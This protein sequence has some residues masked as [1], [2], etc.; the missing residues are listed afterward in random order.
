MSDKI[1]LDVDIINIRFKYSDTNTVSDVEYSNS[2]KDRPESVAVS[3]S[4]SA[5][6]PTWGP[7]AHHPFPREKQKPSVR[8]SVVRQMPPGAAEDATA[9]FPKPYLLPLRC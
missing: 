4:S 7:Y 3:L 5:V 2:N 6:P 9:T 1:G 8:A